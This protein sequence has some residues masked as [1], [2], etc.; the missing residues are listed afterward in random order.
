MSNSHVSPWLRPILDFLRD[1]YGVRDG[2]L[3]KVREP[4]SRPGEPQPAVVLTQTM[5]EDVWTESDSF[6]NQSKRAEDANED[7]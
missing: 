6:D 1:P 2:S 5:N 3:A 7:E 4:F